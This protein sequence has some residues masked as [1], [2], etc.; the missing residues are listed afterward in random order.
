M[1]FYVIAFFTEAA[2]KPGDTVTVLDVHANKL[3][4]KV[5]AV[6]EGFVFVSRPEE[7]DRARIEHREPLCIGFPLSDVISN[8][9]NK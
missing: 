6:E 7:L 3:L 8:K 4:R 2:M 1:L 5:I 9:S